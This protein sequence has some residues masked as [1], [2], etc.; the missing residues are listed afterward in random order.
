M[1]MSSSLH[2]LVCTFRRRDPDEC[3]MRDM[4]LLIGGVLREARSIRLYARVESSSCANQVSKFCTGGHSE[5]E[6]CFGRRQLPAQ[7]D[8][9]VC[10]P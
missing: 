3:K 1:V 2:F 10:N 8:G 4:P 6:H 5:Q 7:A 9:G